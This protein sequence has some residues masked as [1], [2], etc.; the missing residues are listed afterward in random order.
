MKLSDALEIMHGLAA[1]GRLEDAD[2]GMAAQV[3]TQR[4][5]V[6]TVEDLIVN[7][8]EAL[9]DRFEAASAPPEIDL[10]AVRAVSDGDLGRSMAICLELACQQ[11]PDDPELGD[12]VARMERAIDVAGDFWVRHGSELLEEMTLVPIDWPE[13]DQDA[14]E[15]NTP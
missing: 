12:Q 10:D 1:E 5:A 7:H 9:D 4:L 15:E 14:P 8:W 13:E 11:I 3:E 6:A 2:P